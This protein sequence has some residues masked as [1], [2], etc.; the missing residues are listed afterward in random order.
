M[1]D[2][3]F[4]VLILLPSMAFSYM[5]LSTF[6]GWSR[7]YLAICWVPATLYFIV[8]AFLHL[9]DSNYLQTMELGLLLN[10]VIWVSFVQGAL[11]VVLIG[12]AAIKK[13]DWISLAISTLVTLIPFLIDK[14]VSPGI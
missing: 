4:A 14:A 10:A 7:G 3:S 13:G 12:R 6:Y 5:V 11:G 2:L 8:N 9:P 1:N